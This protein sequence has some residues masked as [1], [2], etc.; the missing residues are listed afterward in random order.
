LQL[1]QISRDGGRCVAV[2]VLVVE[3]NVVVLGEIMVVL[4]T[5]VVVV[6]GR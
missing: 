5:A 6:V 4:D 1:P 3:A 2:V